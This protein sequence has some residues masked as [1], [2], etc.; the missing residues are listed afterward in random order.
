LRPP[1]VSRAVALPI[2]LYAVLGLAAYFPTWPG[3]PS[4]IP[5]CTCADAGLNTWFLAA[6]AHA[7][8]H[9][10]NL[11]FTSVLNYPN[12]VNLTYNTQ[13]PL[14]GL[15]TTPLT[16][17]AGPIASLNLLMWL[18]FPLS[19]SSMFL[20]L[21]RWTSWTP[22]AFAGGLLYGFSPYM[23]GQSTAHLHL[24]FIPLPPLI[25]LA[26]FELFARRTGNP[27][28][29]G[30]VLGLLAAGQFLISSEVL[31]TTGLV[32][33]IGLAILAIARPS[34]VLVS[35]RFASGGLLRALVVVAAVLAYPTW[36]FFAGPEHYT[37]TSS[38]GGA[39]LLRSDLLSPL[40]PTSFERLTPGSWA[41]T[42]NNL[43]AFRDYSEN[44]SYLG[45][46][47]LLVLVYI[48]ARYWRNRWI[49]FASAMA[50]VTFVLS[51]GSPLNIDGHPT[52]VPLPDAL[53]E[54]LPLVN[55]LL[56]S[57]IAMFTALFV[58]TIVALGIDELRFAT[59]SR[60]SPEDSLGRD[61]GPVRALGP[62]QWTAVLLVA[63]VAL[64]P[65]VPRWPNRTVPTDIPSYFTSTNVDRISPGTVA[66]TYPYA[67]PLHAQPMVWQA[68]T[69][70]RFS[71]IGGYAL[72]PNA[73][74]VLTLLP[75][76]LQPPAVQRFFINEAGGIPFYD[77]APV[78][79][80]DALV[81]DVRHFV[82]RYRVGVVLVDTATQNS[83]QV[84]GL[85]SRALGQAPL[86]SGGVD[87]WYD[88]QRAPGLAVPAS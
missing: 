82:L 11:F 21:R 66:L 33:V 27:R 72:I 74:G 52:G 83:R 3:D 51:L 47:L 24:M 12:G 7:V 80:N 78:A 8:A 55:Q 4:R 45:V 58:G 53:L 17:T 19:A 69:D 59:R 71:L 67:T 36:V 40:V 39:F 76:T 20:V 6:T 5:Q 10:H 88:V 26:V 77:S 15:V 79:D 44:G 73:H 1:R 63:A 54:H 9:G 50:V 22:A 41:A 16:L 60:Q 48:V 13:M 62:A 81:T 86:A 56:P 18:A 87:V 43:T 2:A 28:R 42:G 35:L 32:V 68:V 37:A 49:R 75:S 65:L 64:L 84:D 70:M 25:M 30:V 34:Q 61:P 85:L 29:W 14:L 23:V 46:P 31:V 57:R 38:T